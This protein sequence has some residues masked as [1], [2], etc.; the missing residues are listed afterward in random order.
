VWNGRLSIA[1]AAG[2]GITTESTA[3]RHSRIASSLDDEEERREL[4]VMPLS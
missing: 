2:A 3:G 1:A 4:F